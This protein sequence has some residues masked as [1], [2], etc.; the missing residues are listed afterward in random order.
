MMRFGWTLAVVALFAALGCRS[1]PPV[2]KPPPQPEVLTVPP[3]NEARFD[4]SQM[5]DV[6]FRDMNDRFRKPIESANPIV[7]TRGNMGMG[8]NGMSGSGMGLR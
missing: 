8:P 6:A 4:R 7:P 5:P 2:V 1:T 3:T